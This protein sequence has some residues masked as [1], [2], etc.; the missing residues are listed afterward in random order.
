MKIPT[1]ITFRDMKASPAVEA[2]IYDEVEKLGQFY[3]GILKCRVT[4]EIPH[5]H[6]NAGNRFHVGIDLIVPGGEIVTRNKA[7]L[8]ASM[9]AFGEEVRTKK[10]EIAATHKD[11]YVAIRDAFNAARRQLQDFA[12]KQ[13][14][15]VKHHDT[16]AGK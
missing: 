14:G 3:A 8:H 2:K 6:R 4:I 13:R 15:A 10:Q 1:D 11:I 12:R 7:S 9:Q 5:E 16:F